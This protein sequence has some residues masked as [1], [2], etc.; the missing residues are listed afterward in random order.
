MCVLKKR[1]KTQTDALLILIHNDGNTL[2]RVTEE[3]ERLAIA[4]RVKLS[5]AVS[6]KCA[7][8]NGGICLTQ[9]MNC[10]A[11]VRNQQ[12]YSTLKNTRQLSLLYGVR[13][14]I[15]VDFWG[16]FVLFPATSFFSVLLLPI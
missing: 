9:W 13:C 14:A 16:D 10:S 15:Y 4:M 5:N 12:F 3:M 7:A 6:S 11:Y 2:S 1:L 8:Q